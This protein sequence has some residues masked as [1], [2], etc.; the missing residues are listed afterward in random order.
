MTE[1]GFSFNPAPLIPYSGGVGFHPKLIKCSDLRA[2]LWS[3]GLISPHPG[4][5]EN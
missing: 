4:G 1:E 5:S 3:L 2:E